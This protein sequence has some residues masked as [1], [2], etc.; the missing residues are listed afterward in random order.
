MH[1]PGK[2]RHTDLYQSAIVNERMKMKPTLIILSI[3]FTTCVLTIPVVFSDDDWREY[4]QQSIGVSS[5]STPLYKEECGSCH[6]A[7]P[8]GLLPATSWEKIMTHLD[9]H[10][11]DNAELDAYTYKSISTFLTNNSADKSSYRRSKKIINSLVNSDQPIRITETPYFKHEHDE[12]PRKM[13]NDNKQVNSFSNCNA[14]HANAEQ[15]LFDEHSI[16]IPGYGHWDD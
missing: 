15:G 4:R 2:V 11:D 9:N 8:P 14:C 16:H 13:V 6:M 3:L 1:R 12:I 5:V 10:F 7:Y